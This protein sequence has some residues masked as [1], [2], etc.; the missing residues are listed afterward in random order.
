MTADHGLRHVDSA[1]N[2]A[3]MANGNA[4]HDGPNGDFHMDVDP[5]SPQSQEFDRPQ[6]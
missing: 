4:G 3:E 2:L 1:I 5:P 6:G